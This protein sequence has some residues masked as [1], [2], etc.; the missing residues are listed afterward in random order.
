MMS[1]I[2][3]FPLVVAVVVLLVCIISTLCHIP[4]ESALGDDDD[5]KAKMREHLVYDIRANNQYCGIFLALIGVIAT[6]VAGDHQSFS[7]V[8]NAQHLWPFGLAV[9]AGAI[10]TLFVPAGYGVGSFQVLR[11]VWT[12]SVICEQII[13]I[14][15]CYGIWSSFTTLTVP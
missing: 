9:V 5:S 4:V 12:R 10:S 8:L 13:V 14:F 6:I 11:V 7:T 2:P 3:F 1:L 15:T